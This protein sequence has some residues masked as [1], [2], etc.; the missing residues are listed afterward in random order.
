MLVESFGAPVDEVFLTIR[1]EPL[2][3][4]SIAQVRC[5]MHPV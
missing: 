4:G 3:S 5:S 2:A 1:R